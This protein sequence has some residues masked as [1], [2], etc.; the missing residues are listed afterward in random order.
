MIREAFII[1][2]QE[3]VDEDA[4]PEI[5]TSPDH[6][7]EEISEGDGKEEKIDGG[8]SSETSIDSEVHP[9]K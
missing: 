3:G 7:L 8:T 1:G 2:F 9:G 5:F 6:L 4:P